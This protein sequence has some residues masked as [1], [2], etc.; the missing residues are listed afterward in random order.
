[1]KRQGNKRYIFFLKRSKSGNGAAGLP[2]PAESDPGVAHPPDRTAEDP[3]LRL[4]LPRSPGPGSVAERGERDP[5]RNRRV[6]ATPRTF[7]QLQQ[8]PL[9]SGGAR[10]LRE[11]GEAGTR[12]EPRPGPASGQA[13]PAEASG[14]SGPLHERVRRRP[15]VPAAHAGAGVAGHGGEPAA[16]PTPRHPQDGE[17]AHA[18][19]AEE[20][21]GESS[22]EHQQDA[23][24][25]HAGPE[26]QPTDGHPPRHGGHGQPQLY[27]RRIF[28]HELG[29]TLVTPP[30]QR[31]RHLPRTPA[32]A[33][34]V[35][36]IQERTP[37]STLEGEVAAGGEKEEEEVPYLQAI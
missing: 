26:Q 37:P 22:R 25:G 20:P 16:R 5:Q 29:K 13:E 2:G 36:E 18:V 27:K 14:S 1:M 19:A 32:A 24:P 34:T 31:R 3:Q 30:I 17:A 28:L 23:P 33:A 11:S 12:H 4:L 8:S 15:A 7:A 21:A 6:E 10:R 9:C 35:R